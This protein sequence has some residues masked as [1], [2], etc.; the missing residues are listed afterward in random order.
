MNNTFSFCETV[1][2]NTMH[3]LLNGQM[4]SMLV[5]TKHCFF[6]TSPNKPTKYLSCLLGDD[7]TVAALKPDPQ[8]KDTHFFT[9]KITTHLPER[10][11]EDGDPIE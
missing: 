4:R 3:I 7:D 1:D 11:L 10:K 2:E 8:T 6:I 9:K 5:F